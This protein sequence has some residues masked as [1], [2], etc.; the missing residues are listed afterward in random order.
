MKKMKF[1]LSCLSM[2]A[3]AVSFTACDSKDDP[4]DVV[5]VP[6]PVVT[7]TA[8]EAGETTLN[9]TLTT[10]KAQEAAWVCVEK[11]ATVTAESVLADGAAV[12][13]N[14]TLALMAE[15]LTANTEY[16]I[17][18][19]AKNG[20]KLTLSNA[21]EMKTKEATVDPQPEMPTVSVEAVDEKITAETITFLITS[22]NADEVK[23]AVL[24]ETALD[25]YGE[26]T[27][28]LI[29]NNSLESVEANAT[30]EVTAEVYMPDTLFLVYAVA[31]KGDVLVLSEKE[32]IRTLAGDGPVGPE[33]T[34]E[35]PEP[36]YASM[37]L[38]KG[39]SLDKYEFNIADEAG[40]LT[41]QFDL[42][43]RKGMNGDL[44]MNEYPIAGTEAG[45]IDP[46]T[47]N[48]FLEGLP[49][50]IVDGA[51]FMEIYEDGGVWY[52]LI[53]GELVAADE[54]NYLLFYD[55]EI[56]L[57]GIQQSGGNEDTITFTSAEYSRPTLDDG[58]TPVA[59]Q[60]NIFLMDGTD[61]VTLCFRGQDL[62]YLAGDYY[63]VGTSAEVAGSTGA[64]VDSELSAV[65]AGVP[66]IPE[67]LEAGDGSNY[68]VRVET[69]LDLEPTNPLFADYYEIDFVIKT[70]GLY[71]TPR[72]IKGHYEGPL[73]FPLPGQEKV[74]NYD[75][76]YNYV[77]I[78]T[79][80][81]NTNLTFTTT[82]SPAANFK[83]NIATASL[84]ATES[85]D[86]TWYDINN[87]T[88]ND[89]YIGQGTVGGENPQ[90]GV[91]F[92]GETYD[93]F[94]GKNYPEYQFTTRNVELDFNGRPFSTKNDWRA[95]CTTATT[96]EPEIEEVD[97]VFT[98]GK[99]VT[100]ADGTRTEVDM[101][102][103]AGNSA[104]LV[105]R[106]ASMYANTFKYLY[107]SGATYMLGTSSN[108]MELWTEAEE[109]TITYKGKTYALPAADQEQEL[110]YGFSVTCG[111]PYQDMNAISLI[112]PIELDGITLE[113]FTFGGS[114]YANEQTEEKPLQDWSKVASGYKN[115]FVESTGTSHKVTLRSF[116]NG[117][118]VFFIEGVDNIYGKELHVGKEITMNSYL[119]QPAIE[120]DDE[121]TK[122]PIVSG[123]IRLNYSRDAATGEKKVQVYTGYKEDPQGDTRLKFETTT[124][125][126][127]FDSGDKGWSA[128]LNE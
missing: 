71:S 69:T 106:L 56:N 13:A 59:G 5:E 110:Y 21:L 36:V 18:A 55:G 9:F 44:G 97:L 70:K 60:F 19:A 10:E 20:T 25:V 119:Y 108:G 89:P 84:P 33:E 1:I 41:L 66:P 92:L 86:W 65:E 29:Y 51:I 118:M 91:K 22:E 50:E 113:S 123:Y 53:E 26:I 100:S 72:E 82:A 105:F 116:S 28:E 99:A 31:K 104:H 42:Y 75:L 37:T 2:L 17:Y 90:L 15:N 64:W 39:A 12:E 88:I 6:A 125:I 30:V 128:T 3:L 112:M 80:G 107:G 83:V 114:L 47:M 63:A 77:A 27:A 38:K 68:Y 14:K 94:E 87:G 126:I 93:S 23:F 127:W 45:M 57:F 76:Y 85:S 32:E 61:R 74:E 24:P 67:Q 52:S 95:T 115:M 101:T 34:V 40:S 43:T 81:E 54:T 48:L 35:L 98:Q 111:M 73:G 58:V 109:S 117:D 49:I 103:E 4:D 120:M 96:S 11:G 78:E 102:D 46:Q 124:N 16:A 79:V 121:G 62:A 122:A 8:G 7:L